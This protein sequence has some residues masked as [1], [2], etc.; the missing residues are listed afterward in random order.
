M[1]P[2]NMNR[3]ELEAYF[4]RLV[5]GK[6]IPSHGG[7]WTTTELIQLAEACLFILGEPLSS[8]RE[9]CIA[10]AVCTPDLE[11]ARA[12]LAEAQKTDGQ[13]YEGMVWAIRCLYADTPFG[14][15]QG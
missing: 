9:Q 6:R 15:M 8:I 3:P 1:P 7:S 5:E 12:L 14:T 10:F 11:L 13:V 4:R 2:A